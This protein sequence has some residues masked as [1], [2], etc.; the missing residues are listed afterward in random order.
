MSTNN[1]NG[2]EVHFR[3]PWSMLVKVVTGVT[4][5]FLIAV[6][7]IGVTALP[8]STPTFARCLMIVAPLLVLAGTALFIVRDYTVREGELLIQRLF[9]TTRIDLRPLISATINPEALRRSIRLCGSGGLFGII[10]WFRN[11]QLGTYRAYATDPKRAVILKLPNRV[12]VV[13]PDRPEEFVAEIARPEGR[14]HRSNE[15]RND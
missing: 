10:G 14:V 9:W 7:I 6:P 13:T 11:K 15:T 8:Q 1:H 3:A 4:S 5:A 12:L 2:R